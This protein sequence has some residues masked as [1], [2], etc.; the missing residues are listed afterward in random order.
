MWSPAQ[1]KYFTRGCK[2]GSISRYVN[3]KCRCSSCKKANTVYQRKRRK[4]HPNRKVSAIRSQKYL[5]RLNQHSMGLRSVAEIAEMTFGHLRRIRSG[6]I[7]KVRLTTQ[8]AILSVPLI[9]HAD[10]ALI[11]G[12]KTHRMITHLRNEGFT[13]EQLALKFEM[14]PRTIKNFVERKHYVLAKTQMKVEK[15][16]NRVMAA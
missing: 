15:F 8:N 9:A 5:R 12:H 11:P 2:H 4:P 16:Y 13:Y 1:L 3:R 14:N 7:R 6:E 10:A